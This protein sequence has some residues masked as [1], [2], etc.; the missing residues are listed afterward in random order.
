M[1]IHGISQSTTAIEPET[2]WIC[3]ILMKPLPST[4]WGGEIS[5]SSFIASLSAVMMQ[6]VE[7]A[8]GLVVI[9]YCFRK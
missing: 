8:C 9:F 5:L 1:T 3:K 7:H 4:K 2:L 6:A